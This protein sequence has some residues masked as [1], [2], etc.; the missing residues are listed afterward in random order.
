LLLAYLDLGYGSYGA[1][2]DPAVVQMTLAEIAPNSPLWS[3]EPYLV[4]VAVRN[5]KR[6][7]QYAKYILEIIN[8]HPDPE[9]KESSALYSHRIAKSWKGKNAALFPSFVG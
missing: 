9:V 6:E 7:A 5:S 8:N 3:F 2:L 1:Q 4:E